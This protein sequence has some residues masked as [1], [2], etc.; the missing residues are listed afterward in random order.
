MEDYRAYV[1]YTFLRTQI[2]HGAKGPEELKIYRATFYNC[3]GKKVWTTEIYTGGGQIEVAAN[4]AVDLRSLEATQAG[5]C[6]P[7]LEEG[8]IG[9]ETEGEKAFFAAE[10]AMK[11]H[12]RGYFGGGG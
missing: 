4:V 12:K 10:E 2:R 8:F 11:L 9:G 5:C 6:P 1:R 3:L 7:A